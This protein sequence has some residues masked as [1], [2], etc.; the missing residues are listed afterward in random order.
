LKCPWKTKHEHNV[1]C[2][3]ECCH[4]DAV[5]IPVPERKVAREC[6]R[7]AYKFENGEYSRTTYVLKP[8]FPTGYAGGKW[9]RVRF[10]E[11]KG[12]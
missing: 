3:K 2:G 8:D 7:W 4:S 12:K 5:C 9:V 11:V 6:V 10:T 1:F